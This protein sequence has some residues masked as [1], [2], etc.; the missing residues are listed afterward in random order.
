MNNLNYYKIML[1]KS[2][3]TIQY[4]F[5]SFLCKGQDVSFRITHCPV[6]DK[7]SLSL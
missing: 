7:I 3:K 4:K 6:I 2:E 5:P 1:L